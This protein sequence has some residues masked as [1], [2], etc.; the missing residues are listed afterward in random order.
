VKYNIIYADPPWSYRSKHTGGSMKSG[1]SDKYPVLT[2]EQLRQF[3]IND[4]ADKDSVLFMWGTTPMLQEA[5][6]VVKAWGHKYKTTL[7][8]HKTGRLGLGYWARGEVEFVLM[9]IKGKVKAFRSTETNFVEAPVR[10]HSEKPEEMRQKIERMTVNM[11][12]QR[13]IELFA[14]KKV[15]GWDAWGNQVESDLK[16]VIG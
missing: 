13:R 7:Y 11:P 14:R 4:I 2:V 8:W 3:P 10:E 6:E 16:L 1:A 15:P 5:L 9:G 12:D